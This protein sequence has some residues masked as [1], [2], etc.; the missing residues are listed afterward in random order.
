LVAGRHGFTSAR[1]PAHDDGLPANRKEYGRSGSRVSW[2]RVLDSA[3]DL[4]GTEVCDWLSQGNHVCAVEVCVPG[5][6][7]FP[8]QV[9]IPNHDGAGRCAENGGLVRFHA[10]VAYRSAQ[11]GVLGFSAGG[12]LVAASAHILRSACTSL[13][14]RP[15]KKAAAGFC[16]GSLSGHMLQNT[17]KPFELNPYVPVTREAPPTF[18]VASGR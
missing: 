13:W 1:S 16:R 14:T 9:H 4:E 2:R 7:L 17:S 5:E 18:I 3:I 15:T 10:G 11:I 6:G 8:N 12:H